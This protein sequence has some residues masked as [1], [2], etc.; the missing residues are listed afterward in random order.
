MAEAGM[1][2]DHVIGWAAD[3]SGR[4]VG[5][6]LP[7]D[8]VGFETDRIPVV[9]GCVPDRRTAGS[10]N[11]LNNKQRMAAGAGEV[12][13]LGGACLIAMES[14]SSTTALGGCRACPRSIHC[15]DRS[16]GAGRFSS[17]AR[18]SVSNRPIR[19]L[20]AACPA[21]ARPPTIH[22]IAGSHP[23]RSA[24]FTSSWPPRRPKTDRRNSPVIACRPFLPVRGSAGSWP[25]MSVKPSA[26]SSSRPGRPS[27]V[28]G[29]SA[30]VERELQAAV[31]IETK[32]HLNRFTRAGSPHA[33]PRQCSQLR[34]PGKCAQA[35]VS[36]ICRSLDL[37]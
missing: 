22:R 3:G 37:G 25:A 29:D 11:R 2:A 7:K 27:G 5:D 4:K 23:G 31:E 18:N 36:A 6:A 24:S 16:A 17:P 15:P 26:S 21:K 12:P 1:G 32:R 35:G 14:M 30:T 9:L 28:G 13:I 19:P 33:T 8:R 20:H 34:W 10:P